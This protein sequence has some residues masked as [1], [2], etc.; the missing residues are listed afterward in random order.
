MF[1]GGLWPRVPI[2]HRYI[3]RELLTV[4]LLAATALTSLTAL[5]GLIQPLRKHGVTAAELAEILLLLFPV[6]L[7]FIL[8]FAI[9]LAC[10]W[11]YGR[12]SADNELNACSSS[13]INIQTL[14]AA[15]LALGVVA[16]LLSGVLANWVVPNW[17][18]NRFQS[19]LARHGKDI[20]YRQLTRQGSCDLSHQQ[21]GRKSIIHADKIYPNENVLMGIAVAVYAKDGKHIE[22]IVTADS[23][24][25][26]FIPPDGMPE[27]VAIVPQQ[28]TVIE[29]PEYHTHKAANLVLRGG[30][31]GKIH[32]DFTSMSLG[33]L[34]A[35][36]EDPEQYRQ[37]GELSKE[38]RRIFVASELGKRLYEQLASQGYF[39]LYGER[40]YRIKGEARQVE[41][42]EEGAQDFLTNAT[43]EEYDATEES[44][45]RT[46]RKVA[47]LDLLVV[48]SRDE[49]GKKLSASVVMQNALV[50]G[51]ESEVGEKELEQSKSSIEGLEI[52]GDILEKGQALSLEKIRNADFTEPV[53]GRLR[54]MSGRLELMEK[55]LGKEITVEIH[56][57]LAMA[58]SC[59]ILAV[60]G[61]LLGAIF[62]KGQFLVAV[63][64]CIGPAVVATL[65]IVMGQR[66]VDVPTVSA[67][68]AA[69]VA[70][71]G[72]ILL[73]AANLVL[74]AKVLRR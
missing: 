4:C 19:L 41:Y 57:R 45:S 67:A 65:F 51:V 32:Q 70:W 20:V 15:P 33:E 9:M 37:I 18:L 34:Q 39:E 49:S 17:A 35:M 6:V 71:M 25:L 26:Q 66:M 63:G 48:E 12:L 74:G 36:R 28:A 50:S 38:A 58:V 5:C 60:L 56:S 55:E 54:K 40:R 22:R 1:F 72:L 68:T 69:G 44:I 73:V 7:V 21:F 3:G 23:A 31:R 11:V 2:I 43:V 59:P 14:L 30:I 29:L 62:R 13:G 47:Q 8:P 24:V 10:C 52:A 46:F 16:M 64:L 27:S 42:D 61:A 53:P